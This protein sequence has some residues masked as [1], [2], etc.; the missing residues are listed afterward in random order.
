MFF[1]PSSS[2][3]AES[4]LLRPSITSDDELSCKL[5]T[6]LFNSVF[7]SNIL[8]LYS[9]CWIS[10]FFRFTYFSSV[11]EEASCLFTSLS[12]LVKSSFSLSSVIIFSPASGAGMKVQS[13][14]TLLSRVCCPATIVLCSEDNLSPPWVVF[15][16]INFTFVS[17]N[18][19]SSLSHSASTIS[20]NL[21][22]SSTSNFSLSTCFSKSTSRVCFCSNSLFN[23]SN[24]TF[25]SS[26]V[27]LSSS[28]CSD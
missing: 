15:T 3:R 6:L 17:S 18:S 10:C 28:S 12:S 9:F 13:M 21:S 24:S 16:S 8:S 11:G 14:L 22:A 7:S 27:L 23:S 1:F 4:F 5:L 2:F 25:N 19:D 26:I 20:R